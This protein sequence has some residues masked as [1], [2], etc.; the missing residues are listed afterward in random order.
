M[1]KQ[2]RKELAIIRHKLSIKT[3]VTKIAKQMGY[4]RMGLGYRFLTLCREE[5]LEKYKYDV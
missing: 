3:P 5:L 1:T 4:T 2:D